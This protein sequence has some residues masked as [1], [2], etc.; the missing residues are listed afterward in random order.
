LFR[1]FPILSGKGINGKHLDAIFHTSGQ[2]APDILG[3]GTV[4]GQPGEAPL[5]GPSA[6]AIHNDT[7]MVG[8]RI[9]WEFLV[10]Y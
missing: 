9:E 2:Y 8:Y 4:T 7:E 6:V 5:S 3:A 10:H 1:A